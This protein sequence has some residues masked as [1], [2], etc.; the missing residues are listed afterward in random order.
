MQKK[1]I[2]LVDQKEGVPVQKQDYETVMECPR[3]EETRGY[4]QEKKPE[5]ELLDKLTLGAYFFHQSRPRI[6]GKLKS[7]N[8]KKAEE[9]Q[10]DLQ[11][12]PTGRDKCLLTSGGP[13]HAR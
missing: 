13:L 3:E 1:R 6:A 11:L 4:C 12:K 7:S 5:I 9:K 2:R 10:A 8:K